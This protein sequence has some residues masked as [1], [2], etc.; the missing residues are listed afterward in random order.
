MPTD[1]ERLDFLAEAARHSPTGISIDFHPPMDGGTSGFR[2]MRY[3]RV[4]DVNKTIRDAIDKAMIK[5]VSQ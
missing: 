5:G 1:T 2:F 4:D 3:H